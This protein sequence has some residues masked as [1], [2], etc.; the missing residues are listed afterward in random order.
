MATTYS[1]GIKIG[2]GL[3]IEAPVPVDDRTVVPAVGDLIS[4]PNQYVGLIATPLSLNVPFIRKPDGWYP[5]VSAV[6]FDT[7]PTQGSTNAVT[8]NGIYEALQTKADLVDGK[9]PAY[10]LPNAI[11]DIKNGEYIDEN[12]FN[13]LNGNPYSPELDSVY[14]DVN[15]NLVYRWSGVVYVN[16]TTPLALGENAITAYRGDRGKIAYDHSLITDGSNPHET[17]HDN[18]L[19]IKG[20]GTVHISQDDADYL[21]NLVDNDVIG[22]LIGAVTAHPDYVA[23]TS[24]ITNV[25]ATYEV[26]ATQAISLTQVFTQNNG[27]AKTSEV[28]TKNNST[29]STTNTFSETLSVPLGNTTYS[30]N[31][32]Y[33]Q[34]ACIQ[35]NLGIVDCTGRIEAGQTTSP[36]RTITGA[37]RRYAGNIATFPTTG[38][39]LRTA[40]LGTSVINTSNNFT[41]TTGT[42]NRRF[43]IAIPAAKTLSTVQNTGTNEFLNFTLSTTLT[44]VPD[45]AG[46]N[47]SY[48]VYTLENAV[49]FPQNY[50]LNVI[51]T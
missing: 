34:G 49:P 36:I 38:S 29:V 11:S 28:I 5:I 39:A 24:S 3:K 8:S 40:L 37:Y 7:T 30:G 51:L 20:R 35:N 16:I 19:E 14:V 17:E 45:A 22:N 43:I 47:A 26:G 21:S 41:F 9:V 4:I 13:D 48:K 12:T 18:L 6:N 32:N 27:G 46:N 23:P 33:V 2:S 15:T 31:V 10:Q 44:T 25:T 1:G 42:T 50:T